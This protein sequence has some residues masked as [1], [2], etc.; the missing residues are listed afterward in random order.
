MTKIHVLKSPSSSV[1][2][3]LCR[4]LVPTSNRAKVEVGLGTG[5]IREITILNEGNNYASTPTIAIDPPE[6]GIDPDVVALLT[7]PNSN[8]ETPAIKQLVV[9]NSGAG[10]SKA[11]NVRAVGGNGTGSVIR[12][13]IS[14]GIGVVQ[15]TVE[16]PGSGYAEDADII[17]YDGDNNIVAQ[18]LALTNG[19]NIAKAIIT[20]PGENL[21]TDAYAVVADP[22][23][24]GSGT[25]VYNEIVEGLQSGTQARIRGWDEVTLQLSLTNLDPEEKDVF[26]QPGEVVIGKTSG[27]RYSVKSYSDRQTADDKYSQ[28]NEIEDVAEVV[29][30][31]SEFNQFAPQ[32]YR[33]QEEDEFDADNPFGEF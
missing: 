18:G 30:D 33:Q 23:P 2:G 5:Y 20:D 21:T 29:V 32:A 12:A 24:T 31:Q 13:G 7:A 26:F 15:F 19:S 25:Y 9:F 10:Y 28:N 1:Q 16:D 6:V 11:P 27:A 14:T 8:I 3:A 17:V 4:L 22:S